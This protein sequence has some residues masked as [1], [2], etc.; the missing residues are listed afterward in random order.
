MG[1]PHPWHTGKRFGAQPQG[2]RRGHGTRRRR[3]GGARQTISSIAKALSTDQRARRLLRHGS[4]THRANLLRLH[5]AVGR[6]GPH[7]PTQG[8]TS[9]RSTAFVKWRCDFE[10]RRDHATFEVTALASILRQASPVLRC[11]CR[12]PRGR[13][14]VVATSLSCSRVE[15]AC[16]STTTLSRW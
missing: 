11:N 14:P 1:R 4:S 2:T 8:V 3:S 13:F 9:R 15:P 7:A 12:A 16:F 5:G 6:N 10:A